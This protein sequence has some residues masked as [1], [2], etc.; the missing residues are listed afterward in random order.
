MQVFEDEH[1][2]L[3]LTLAQQHALERLQRALP[4]LRRIER[5]K[6][7]VRREGIEECQQRR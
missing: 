3:H 2:R 7:A 4:P 5:Q 6:R 1:Q